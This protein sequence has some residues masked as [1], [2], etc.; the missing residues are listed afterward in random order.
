MEQANKPAIILAS[1][2]PRRQEML[3]NLGLEFTIH[4]SGAD[5][6][7]EDGLK[8]AKIVELLAERKAADV[9]SLYES[10]IVIGSD[11]IVVLGDKVLG[12]PNN[13]EDAFSMLSALQGTTH[14]VYSGL[15]LIDANNGNR[16]VGHVETKVRM[17][18]VS[19]D[20]ILR[21]IATKEPMDKAGAYAIQ[22]LGSIFVEGI[23][24]DYF[25]VVGLP[26]QM[27]ASYL[28]EFGFSIL[29]P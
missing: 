4:P 12:K 13:E 10:G 9:A 6:S 18:P 1:S 29:T 15:A 21:Y 19:K 22:G 7:V 17:R 5:E 25:S 27:M 24:G 11:T 28:E 23:V 16:R 3:R 26:V 14:S 20:E 2:S 8:P